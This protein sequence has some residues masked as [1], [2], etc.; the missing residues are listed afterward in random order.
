MPTPLRLRLL[1]GN[2]PADVRTG[3][4]GVAA[5]LDA[6]GVGFEPTKTSLPYRFS[7][8]APSATR[9]TL[10]NRHPGVRGPCLVCHEPR[11]DEPAHRRRAGFGVPEGGP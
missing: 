7:R 9:R 1:A 4:G 6:E 8:P 2:T 11:P 10:P 5:A 3:Q